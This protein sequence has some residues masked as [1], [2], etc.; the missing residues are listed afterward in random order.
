M[1]RFY[2]NF[3]HAHA[4]AR[5][6]TLDALVK[7]FLIDRSYLWFNFFKTVYRHLIVGAKN[8]YIFFFIDY[9]YTR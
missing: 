2:E 5:T 8:I 9:I 7:I 3:E 6:R 1:V 4:H